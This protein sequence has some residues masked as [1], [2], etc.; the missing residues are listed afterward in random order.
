MYYGPGWSVATPTR[1]SEKPRFQPGEE[2]PGYSAARE[3]TAAQTG[4][5]VP[6]ACTRGHADIPLGIEGD[7][8]ATGTS[9]Q[10]HWSGLT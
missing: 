3:R 7:A 8:S 10:L 1:H 5:I 6:S 9:R 2:S 4:P